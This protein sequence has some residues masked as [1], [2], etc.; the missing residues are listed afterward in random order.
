M[1]VRKNNAITNRAVRNNAYNIRRI[2]EKID[3]LR[4]ENIITFYPVDGL[5]YYISA[6]SDIVELTGEMPK[7]FDVLLADSDLSHV[8]EID[9]VTIF[10]E[11]A[12]RTVSDASNWVFGEDSNGPKISSMTIESVTPLAQLI[13]TTSTLEGVNATDPIRSSF[14]F[15][16]ESLEGSINVGGNPGSV[17]I[18]IQ[19][20]VSG[21]DRA[22]T[23]FW[24]DSSF[25]PEDIVTSTLSTYVSGNSSDGWFINH[26][27]ND[28]VLSDKLVLVYTGNE[29]EKVTKVTVKYK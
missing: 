27:Y 11:V 17:D 19:S 9:R 21:A 20:L 18:G 26:M 28:Q 8:D 23:G 2:D 24:F 16:T 14:R 15:I 4:D 10:G 22:N 13:N 6:T 7:S 1:H 29:L 12:S 5:K 25:I 3:D